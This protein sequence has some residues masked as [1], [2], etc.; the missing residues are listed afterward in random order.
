MKEKL[1]W[2]WKK[3]RQFSVMILKLIKNK[4]Q[5]SQFLESAKQR[6]EDVKIQSE[7]DIKQFDVEEC[8]RILH[9]LEG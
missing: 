9:T 7:G 6:I 4:E 3:E 1:S 5:F 8:F 2:L